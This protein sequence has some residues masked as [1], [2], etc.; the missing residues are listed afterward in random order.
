M[1]RID[2]GLNNSNSPNALTLS[3]SPDCLNVVYGTEGSVETRPGGSIYNTTA[4]GSY[5]VDG[6]ASYN[7]SMLIWANG[8]MYR[9]SGTT[10]ET[11]SS[12]QGCYTAGQKI[13]S[14]V[15]QNMLIFSGGTTG[16]Y[17]YH[18]ASNSVYQL[19][20]ATPTV[21]TAAC[22]TAGAA[23]RPPT[24]ENHYKIT[25]VNTGVVE[26]PTSPGYSLT[27]ATSALVYLSSI[28]VGAASMGV[29]ERY[30]YRAST[31]AGPF[32]YIGKLA[33]NVTTVYT[34]SVGTTTWSA[35]TLAPQ[36]ATA[37]TPFTTVKLHKNRLFFDDSTDRTILRYTDF[38]IP[39]ISQAA[40]FIKINQGDTSYITNIKVQQ[41]LVTV[42]KDNSYWLTQLNDPADDATWIMEEG[43]GHLG[44]VGPRAAVEVNDG[45]IFIGKRGGFI[46]GAHWLSGANVLEAAAYTTKTNAI[47]QRVEDTFKSITRTFWDDIALGLW[48]DKLLI[49][50]TKTGTS[51]N[52]ILWFDTAKLS[53]QSQPGS[54][55]LW[56][57]RV[58]QVGG[59]FE[60][61]GHFYALSA[62]ADG[63]ILE[64]C[65]EAQYND[66][67]GAINSYWWSKPIG[68]EPA[69]ESWM[70]DWRR[71]Y[72]WFDSQDNSYLKVNYKS[73]G[74]IGDGSAATPL[75]QDPGGITWGS[76]VW[77]VGVWGVGGSFE[78]KV[79]GG[80][81]LSR[82]IQIKF[83][84][85][86]AGTASGVTD[87]AFRVNNFKLQCNLRGER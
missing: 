26:G 79:F 67:G 46:T 53:G 51:N 3:E 8:D 15:Y 48:K 74:V 65:K 21:V 76:F 11:I 32:R 80:P 27:L 84:N 49:A 2:G 66:A 55:S 22:N 75:S 69:V 13:E 10:A 56:D 5:V 6:G 29:A 31:S 83:S 58:T 1:D 72:V 30:I 64:V 23:P 57:G 38:L 60:H 7:G 16:P 37:P 47:S 39:Y 4:V 50:F 14:V 35:G 62:L 86:G 81:L 40:N 44:C 77:G 68:G 78:E 20:I 34:D 42:F 17:R 12:G 73:F 52:A 70:K 19:G 18:G 63:F 85:N 82:R 54:W 59:F 87:Y 43:P 33:D 25:Y 71:L 61:L 45:I 24:G 41:D 28:P 36:D 9:I